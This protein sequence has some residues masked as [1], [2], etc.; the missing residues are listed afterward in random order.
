MLNVENQVFNISEIESF[1]L[2]FAKSL[3]VGDLLLFTGELGAGKTTFSRFLITSLFSLN[4]LPIPTSINSPSYPI[5]LTY[6]LRSYEIYHY[7]FY[8]IKNITEIEELDFFENINRS[9]T[10]IE[11]PEI[12]IDLPFKKKHYRI[13]L[14]FYSETERV[15][16][17]K[18]HV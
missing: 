5:L 11:W 15:I 12:L 9:I 14:D 16:N 17:I 1:A 7:D 3:K 13:N 10:L 18:F 6:D 8:R 4:S 2:K